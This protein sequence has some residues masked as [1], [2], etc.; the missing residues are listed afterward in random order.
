MPTFRITSPDGVIYNVTGPEGSTEQDALAQVQQQRVAQPKQLGDV[1]KQFG[2]IEGAANLLSGAVAAPIAGVAGG[3]A[4]LIPGLRPGIGAD[5]VNRVQNALTYQPRSQE[6]KNL[7]ATVAAPFEWLG[8]KAEQA[9]GAVSE[10][11]G[12]P[13]LGAMVNAGIQAAPAIAGGIYGRVGASPAAIAARAKAASLNAPV[14]ATIAAAQDAGLAITPTQAN[15]GMVSRAVEG[16]AGTPRLEKLMSKKNAPVINDLIRKDVGLPED[17]PISRE[18]LA[19][20]RADAGADYEAVK[21]TGRVTTDIKYKMDLAR[22]TNSY[23]MAAKD[24]AHRSENPFAKVMDGLKTVGGAADIPAQTV[25]SQVL[26]ESGKP[27]TKSIPAKNIPASFDAVSAVEEVKLLRADADKAYRTGDPALGKAFK[28]AANAID[29]QLERHVIKSGLPPDTVQAY[30]DARQTIAKT[31]AADKALN[32]TTGNIDA[33]TYARA[34]KNSK[35]LSGE[36]LKVGQFG[37]QFSKSLQPVERVGA[38]GPTFADALIGAVGAGGG[39]GW[40][41]LPG[42]G[43]A[44]LAVSRPVSRMIMVSPPY[45]GLQRFLNTPNY[46]P[47]FSAIAPQAGTLAALLEQHRQQP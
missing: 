8:G 40:V 41:G 24:F 22:I 25:A 11:T 44:A 20:I 39:Y 33:M 4:S 46:G 38:T 15:A 6:G 16:L 1:V 45:Q 47:G 36:G 2:Q 26:Q 14:D 28:S 27:F 32:A 35:F 30:L 42:A 23:D 37:Q 34:L 5:V 29:D 3:V 17:V 13:A 18:S 43:A 7:A 9:G 12:S 19:Q 31:Y 21:N 10:A